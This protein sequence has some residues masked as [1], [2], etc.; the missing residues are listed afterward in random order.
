MEYLKIQKLI[1]TGRLGWC[2]TLQRTNTQKYL[3]LWFLDCFNLSISIM[4]DEYT[5]KYIK[6]N[7]FF[8][9][10]FCRLNN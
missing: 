10:V 6:K 4:C 5:Y 3:C 9:F 1:Q 2:Y 8:I 7:L